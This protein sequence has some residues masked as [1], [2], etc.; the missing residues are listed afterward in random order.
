LDI[1]EES[2]Q[3]KQ[4]AEKKCRKIKSGRIPFSPEA[5]VWIC[6]R[7]VYE[8]LLR[9]K[10]GKIQ[11]RS[12]LRRSALRCGIKRP[13]SLSW[14]GI[15]ERLKVC[16]EKCEYFCKHGQSYRRKHLNNR[17]SIARAKKNKEATPFSI[18]TPQRISCTLPGNNNGVSDPENLYLQ[19]RKPV[20]VTEHLRQYTKVLIQL[21][22]IQHSSERFNL[23]Y[24][25]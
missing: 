16:E 22:S 11:N 15:Q 10:Q 1:D 18:N 25:S 6:R 21:C 8:S 3:Y 9:Y 23:D 17:L 2:K 5:S 20:S 13:L 19:Y 7:Q 12:N 24:F 4:H 14:K